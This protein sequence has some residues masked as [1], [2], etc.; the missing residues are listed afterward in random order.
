M[1]VCLTERITS[2]SK[3]VTLVR[4]LGKALSVFKENKW[5]RDVIII[6]VKL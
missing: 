3:E 6:D 1:Q 4:F 2:V 5:C